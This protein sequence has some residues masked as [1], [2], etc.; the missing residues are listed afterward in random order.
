MSRLR[1]L[2]SG[3]RWVL[4]PE[5][6]HSKK[7]YLD[8]Y[9]SEYGL[10]ASRDRNTGEIAIVHDPDKRNTTKDYLTW[11]I[12]YQKYTVHRLVASHFLCEPYDSELSV[13]HKDG[14]SRNNHYTN[15]MWC[16]WKEHM[17]MEVE[18]GQRKPINDHNINK[19]KYTWEQV[20][21]MRNL[22]ETGNY[23]MNAIASMYGEKFGTMKQ[24]LQYKTYK[25]P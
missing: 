10:V 25:R 2:V 15:L 14:N 23:S 13:H 9:I 22:Y 16:T 11:S 3:E 19:R 6:K 24:I 8:Y 7:P 12:D 17:D 4:M 21:E 1:Y 5:I 20:C 18:A